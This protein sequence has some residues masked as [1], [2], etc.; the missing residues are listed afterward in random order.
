MP[1]LL[2]SVLQ[3]V[4]G[5]VSGGLPGCSIQAFSLSLGVRSSGESDLELLGDLP[6]D[7]V[8]HRSSFSPECL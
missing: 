4:V 8:E 2:R 3:N 7:V 6:L 5:Y 1:R